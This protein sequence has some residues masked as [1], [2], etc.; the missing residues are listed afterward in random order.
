MEEKGNIVNKLKKIINVNG[1]HFL[2]KNPYQ[3]YIE[4]IED[5][6]VDR[7]TAGA[8]LCFL[9]NGLSK[10]LDSQNDITELTKII[11]N[12]CGF[13]EDISYSI[14]EIF[15]NL[16]SKE[17]IKKWK[18]REKEGLKQFL[19]DEFTYKWTGYTIWYVSNVSMDCHYQAE[20]V[21]SP[22]QDVIKDNELAQMLE[23]NP[24]LKKKVIREYFEKK[25][26]KSLKKS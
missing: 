5:G 3:T 20:I 11:Q 2:G 15:V 13:N 9:V 1:P 23:A 7:K 4:L 17:N 26:E 14:A 16:Y 10:Y 21:L 25:L 19:H 8:I 22:T 24:F 12:E 18:S 6:A